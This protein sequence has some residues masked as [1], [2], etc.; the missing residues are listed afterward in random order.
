MKHFGLWLMMLVVVLAACAPSPVSTPLVS[1]LNA[2]QLSTSSTTAASPL[3]PPTTL[4]TTMTSP[5]M[6]LEPTGMTPAPTGGRVAVFPSPII[7]YQ[8]E[9]GITGKSE[10]WTIYPTGRV[11]AG[12]GTEWQVAAEQVKP[13]F[14]LVESPEFQ[15]LKNS[16]PAA[17]TCN[18]CYTHTLT[19]YHQGEPKTV[20]FVEGTGLP[21]VLQKLLGEINKP[22]TH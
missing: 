2:P 7:V 14:D 4:S 12:D 20:T 13:L 1:P 19:V 16:Y 6:P 15:N 18:D 5:L 10:K 3:A 17:N 22:I 21:E 11:V 9:G 8:R